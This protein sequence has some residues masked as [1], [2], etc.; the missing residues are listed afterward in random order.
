MT[1]E[2]KLGHI[3]P[4][5]QILAKPSLPP[6][7]LPLNTLYGMQQGLIH[8]YVSIPIDC[9]QGNLFCAYYWCY[10]ILQPLP[11]GYEDLQRLQMVIIVI[12][13]HKTVQFRFHYFI[14]SQK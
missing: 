12:M 13:L 7:V 4:F 5:P 14:M 2:I 3:F 8:A 10:F 9:F 6:G 1:I 11:Y